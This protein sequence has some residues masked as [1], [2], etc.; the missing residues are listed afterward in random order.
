MSDEMRDRL[1]DV[2]LLSNVEQKIKV[3]EARRGRPLDKDETSIFTMGFIEC[4]SCFLDAQKRN[5][6]Q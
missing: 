2:G 4:F 5:M 1:A 3:F 6:G